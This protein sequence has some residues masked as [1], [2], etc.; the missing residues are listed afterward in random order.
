MRCKKCG[1]IIHESDT[2]CSGCYSSVKDLIASHNVLTEEEWE[3]KQNQRTKKKS[4]EQAH[5]PEKRKKVKQPKAIP[6]ESLKSVEQSSTS[7]SD[8][9]LSSGLPYVE[10]INSQVHA[11]DAITYE[12][13]K[14]WNLEKIKNRW[15]AIGILIVLLLLFFTIL[16]H[17]LT[18]KRL[19]KLTEDLS[20]LRLVHEEAN[21]YV[22][23][24]RNGKA[25]TIQGFETIGN[26][27][28]DLAVA[29]KKEENQTNYYLI[30]LE[31]NIRLKKELYSNIIAT[32]TGFVVTDK[33]TNRVGYLN[34][35]GKTI[36]K[37]QYDSI[38]PLGPLDQ[39][40]VIETDHKYGLYTA[41]GKEIFK[42]K[43]EEESFLEENIK[44]L[45]NHSI[46][47][48]LDGTLYI[49]SNEGTILKQ[50]PKT[51]LVDVIEER[52]ILTI[53]KKTYVMSESQPEFLFEKDGVMSYS[54]NLSD[55]GYV[56]LQDQQK[57]NKIYDLTGNLIY[58]FLEEDPHE[59]L[60]G[61]DYFV[62]NRYDDQKP[63]GIQ[64]Y[65]GSKR[66]IRINDYFIVEGNL[67][68]KD[69]YV[70]VFWLTDVKTKE[71]QYLYNQNGKQMTFSGKKDQYVFADQTIISVAK[72]KETQDYRYQAL[73]KEIV[74]THHY[75]IVKGENDKL[76][77][78]NKEGKEV[79]KLNDYQSIVGITPDIVDVTMPNPQQHFLYNLKE[80]KKIV[81]YEIDTTRTFDYDPATSYFAL[82]IDKKEQRYYNAE[83]NLLY[84][85]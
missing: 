67:E 16:L 78:V 22:F 58:S 26:F 73:E 35:L 51:K 21:H 23:L 56:I 1:S 82:I 36:L 15:I 54:S 38:K 24:D 25:Y 77:I 6:R 45:A 27:V 71:K 14:R 17:N 20:H 19:P 7:P 37:S 34:L 2:F 8:S 66:S 28:A 29:T 43:Y 33:K 39:L 57:N 52:G 42:I 81:S 83:G 32:K 74:D 75:V 80:Q 50:F 79:L 76:G 48:E 55:Y 47:I 62:I 13:V 9:N 85:K 10:A 12:Q 18:K 40:L 31:G 64:V 61:N 4:K 53:A 68:G 5:K 41:L 3:K 70:D 60:F 46:C 65:H 84:Q 59:L 11:Q 72:Y 49:L 30:D 63:I 69:T 44:F